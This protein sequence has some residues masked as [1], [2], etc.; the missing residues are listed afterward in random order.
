M[1]ILFD[2]NLLVRAAL[3]PEGLARKLLD[4][5]DI[6]DEHVVLISTYLLSPTFAAKMSFPAKQGAPSR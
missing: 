3:M 4:L 6:H 1:R 2:T 5:V